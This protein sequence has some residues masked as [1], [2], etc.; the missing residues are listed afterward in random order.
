MDAEKKVNWT[1]SSLSN[2]LT[3]V[4]QVHWIIGKKI[5]STKFYWLAKISEVSRLLVFSS[6]KD[7]NAVNGVVKLSVVGFCLLCAPSDLIW[8]PKSNRMDACW[9]VNERGR[10]LFITYR[11][12]K[13]LKP[14]FIVCTF[15]LGNKNGEIRQVVWKTT[16][17]NDIHFNFFFFLQ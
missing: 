4:K 10:H 3:S 12:L 9:H 15:W 17:K 13:Y 1:S 8:M 14:L 16:I 2:S 5:N 7:W 11:L 6:T